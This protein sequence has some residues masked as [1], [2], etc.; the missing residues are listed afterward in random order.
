MTLKNFVSTAALSVLLGTAA[1][2]CAQD[3]HNDAKPRPEATKP[4]D[5]PRPSRQEEAKPRQDEAKPPK[6]EKR[7][8]EKPS[9]RERAD[10]SEHHEQHAA[11]Q[12]GARIPDDKFREHF[13]RQHTFVVNRVTVIDNQP[14]FQYGG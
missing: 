12:R 11:G 4:P 5:E 2:V 14:R 3:E 13:G 10:Q 6:Q 8:Q 9:T 7:E 1:M